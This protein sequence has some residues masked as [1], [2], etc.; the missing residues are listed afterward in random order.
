[1]SRNYLKYYNSPGDTISELMVKRKISCVEVA[2]LCNC[3]MEMLCD[4]LD[5]RIKIWEGLPGKLESIFN[6]PSSTWSEL[7]KRYWNYFSWTNRIKRKI[8][9]C[10]QYFITYI[11]GIF[12]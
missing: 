2:N 1:M 12:P 9:C 4:L 11:E 3:S 5:G 8:H 6:I 7:D 10:I